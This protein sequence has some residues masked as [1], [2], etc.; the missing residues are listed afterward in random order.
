MVDL[1]N[2][3]SKLAQIDQ[4]VGALIPLVGLVGTLARMTVQMMKSNGLDTASFED[5]IA[6]FDQQR[7]QL[8]LAIEDFDSK[9][10]SSDTPVDPASGG[11]V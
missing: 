5:E 9:Y 3:D 1:N 6:K 7:E 8:R 4:T 2:I 11:G 10:P